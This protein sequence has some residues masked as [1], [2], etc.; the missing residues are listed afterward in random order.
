[1]S[2]DFD[3]Y[4]HTYRDEVQ[5]SIAFSGQ[6]V[7]FFTDVKADLLVRLA[8]RRLGAPDTLE[9]LDVGCGVGLTDAALRGRFGS[10]H[11]VDVS[12]GATQEA[13]VANPW[14][15]YQSFDGRTLPFAD[16]TFDLAFA[17]CVLHHVDPADRPAFARELGRVVRP[18]GLVVAIE[19][20]PLNPLTRVSVSRC[21]FDEGVVL[22]PRREARAL[23]TQDGSRPV[24]RP[25]ILFFP[26]RG[27][28]FRGVERALTWLPLG[29]QYLV[30][31]RK[32]AG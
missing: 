18:G 11:G 6:D 27:A 32:A 15:S 21:D 2:K 25:Y 10:I 22:L 31:V 13:A 8:Q 30:A 17:I 5:R 9:V 14:A 20:N 12:E 7:G 3:E 24:E 1:M 28:A 16:A 26:W 19:H 23:L 29:A 4:R